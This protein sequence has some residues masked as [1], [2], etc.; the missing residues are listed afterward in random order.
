M[1]RLPVPAGVSVLVCCF[2]AAPGRAAA[3]PAGLRLAT[4]SA[5][6]TVPIGPGMM[7]GPW[8]SKRIADPLEAHGFVLLG[9]EPI[10][11]LAAERAGIYL[12]GPA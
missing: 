4:F 2:P 6:V 8:L 10:T 5:D 3:G 1:S 12:T 7:G 11:D 9:G